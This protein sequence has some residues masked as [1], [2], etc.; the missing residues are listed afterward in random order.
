MGDFGLSRV[1]A[2]GSTQ[3][4]NVGNKLGRSPEF[5]TGLYTTKSDIWSLGIHIFY[6]LENTLPFDEKSLMMI[7]NNPN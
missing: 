4:N 3:T 7:L 6:L 2:K 1:Y 5:S